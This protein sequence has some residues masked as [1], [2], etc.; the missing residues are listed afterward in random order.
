VIRLIG[1]SGSLRQGSLN[2]ALL[3]AAQA[4]LPSNL[5]LEVRTLH[6]IPLYDGDLEAQ[7]G[8]PPGVTELKSAIVA[9]DGLLL[10]TP[11]YNHGI[12]GVFK[13]AIDWLSR[14]SDDRKRVFGNRPTALMGV[15]SG[16]F[17]TMAAQDAW[18]AVLLTLGANVWSGSRLM[19][20]RG[21]AVFGGGGALTDA[22]V[23]ERLG[24]FLRGFGEYVAR[25][26]AN[27]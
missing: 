5:A 16:N 1:I 19:V 13:N 22:A 24:A 9:A 11:E 18:L 14:P 25:S 10:A 4:A 17:G 23:Q 26:A 7:Q 6:G 3:R 8:I 27:P 12:P 20:P 21:Q 2:T 15:S